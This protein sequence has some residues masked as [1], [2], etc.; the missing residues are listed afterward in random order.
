MRQLAQWSGTQ[1]AIEW[2]IKGLFDNVDHHILANLLAEIKIG[3][4]QFID[5]YWK[6]VRAGYVEEGVKRAVYLKAE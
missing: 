5:L 6:L 4:Q 3:D 1:W 2:D